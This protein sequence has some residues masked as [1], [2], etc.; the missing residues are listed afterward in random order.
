MEYRA[1]FISQVVGMLIN[2]GIYFVFW[3]LFFDRFKVV[4][5]W[6]ITSLCRVT[7]SCTCW[8]RA[9]FFQRGAT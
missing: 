8:P 6:T 5:G 7:C 1:S 4:R 2:D 9:Q 3:L